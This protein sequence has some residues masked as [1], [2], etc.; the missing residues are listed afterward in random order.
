MFSLVLHFN[1]I[2]ERLEIVLSSSVRMDY[3]YYG[4]KSFVVVIHVKPRDI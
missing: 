1:I 4:K 2:Y 3:L